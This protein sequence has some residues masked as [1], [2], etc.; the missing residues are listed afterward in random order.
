ML[1]PGGMQDSRRLTVRERHDFAVDM[2]LVQI[3]GLKGGD[4]GGRFDVE[5]A[6]DNRARVLVA[7]GEAARPVCHVRRG[8]GRG[9]GSRGTRSSLV[10]LHT[11]RAIL[12]RVHQVERHGRLTKL[13]GTAWAVECVGRRYVCP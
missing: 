10:Q 9:S 6:A 11:A 5:H 2:K 12:I 3:Q 1:V 4:R 7:V 13:S 8:R